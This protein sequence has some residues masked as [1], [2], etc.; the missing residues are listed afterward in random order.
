MTTDLSGREIE[1]LAVMADGWHR[2]EAGALL[3][4]TE[5]TIK[6]HLEHIRAKLDARNTTH[7]VVIALRRG[8]I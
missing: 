3:C 1:V 2:A 4:I 7:A 5:D 6:S 8:L